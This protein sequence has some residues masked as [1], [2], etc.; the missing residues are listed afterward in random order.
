[1]NVLIACDSFKDAL[2]ALKACQAIES[3]LKAANSSLNIRIAPLADGG[4]GLSEILQYH[5][6]VHNISLTISDPLFRPTEARYNSSPEGNIVFIE[7]AQAA[8][9]QQLAITERNP[10]HTTT[11]GVGEMIQ[12]AL[13]S[14]AKRIVLG[15]GGSATHDLGT[16]MATALGWR[17][18]NEKGQPFIPTGATLSQITRILPPERS[19]QQVQ[20]EVMC[21]VTNPLWGEN[22]AAHIYAKQKGADDE[23]IQ[24]LENGTIHFAQLLAKNGTNISPMQAG[25]GAAG[26]MGYGA[27]YFLHA[28]MKKGID[29]ILDLIGFQQLAEWADIIITG[30]GK[31]D[32]Q[33]AQ[34]K[35]ISGLVTHCS[36]QKVIALCGAME[37]SIS[38]IKD[39]GLLAA[40]SIAQGP[41]SLAEALAQTAKHLEIT[42]FQVGQLLSHR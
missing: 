41:C 25:C 22:G 42:A 33:T 13:N 2:G 40:F 23:A 9:L 28:E 12:H 29:V 7:M 32:H 5:L 4:E 38:S 11:Y 37:T 39:M 10:L 24:L 19:P 20:F 8:G 35:L 36:P 3:G 6:G 26:G 30:E 17:F 34:G 14:G 31:L 27:Q 18:I 16:G 21:D 1:M 15:L